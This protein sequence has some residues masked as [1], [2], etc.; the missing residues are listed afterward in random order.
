MKLWDRRKVLTGRNRAES[1]NDNR[2][3]LDDL[4]EGDSDRP[5]TKYQ[6]ELPNCDEAQI[7]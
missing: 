3:V 6:E 4:L 1:L 5:V 7:R 2:R